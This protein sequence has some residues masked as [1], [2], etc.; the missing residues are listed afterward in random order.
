MSLLH[1]SRGAA[2]QQVL[3]VIGVVCAKAGPSAA[4]SPSTLS[5]TVAVPYSTYLLP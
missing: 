2:Q 3:P 1:R 5:L 4:L